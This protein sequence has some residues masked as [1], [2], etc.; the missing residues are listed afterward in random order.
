ML[1]KK[2]Q[3]ENPESARCGGDIQKWRAITQTDTDTSGLL[4]GFMRGPV[5][6]TIS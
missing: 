6:K 5:L 3:E 4:A 2:Q 1:K